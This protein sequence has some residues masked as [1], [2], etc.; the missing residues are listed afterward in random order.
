MGWYR[1][2]QNWTRGE[3]SKRE[4]K[5]GLFDDQIWEENGWNPQTDI[6]FYY[7]ETGL[8]LRI[9]HCPIGL[10]VITKS[11]VIE[12]APYPTEEIIGY[13]DSTTNTFYHRGDLKLQKLE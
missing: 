6:L 5:Y 12:E 2:I 8:E 1:Q 10:Q 9:C 7:G 4:Y 3:E 11:A 13:F